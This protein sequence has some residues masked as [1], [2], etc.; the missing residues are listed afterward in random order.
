MHLLHC[1]LEMAFVEQRAHG[2][3]DSEL[4][5]LGQEVIAV[6]EGPDLPSGS[7]EHPGD[8]QSEGR[9]GPG[10]EDRHRAR[11]LACSGSSAVSGVAARLVGRA[12]GPAGGDGKTAGGT[13][14]NS[15]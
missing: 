6:A 8:L 10:D 7:D 1:R 11:I 15:A 14:R 5:Q 9:G 13:S 3:E 12:V 2:T 4:S